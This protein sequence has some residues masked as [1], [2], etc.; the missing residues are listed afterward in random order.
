MNS[1]T[2]DK[3]MQ[4]AFNIMYANGW[5][6]QKLQYAQ[7]AK[8]SEEVGEAIKEANRLV[9]FSRRLPVDGAFGEELADVV[10]TAYVMAV[11]YRVDIDYSID[12]KLKNIEAR[13]GW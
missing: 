13:G 2:Y 9:G 8:L 7:I 12:E 11:V 3:A 1:L 10:I 5:N 6:Q 4:I